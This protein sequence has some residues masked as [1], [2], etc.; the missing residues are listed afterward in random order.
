MK[1]SASA[2]NRAERPACRGHFLQRAALEP[3]TRSHLAAVFALLVWV[4]AIAGPA[5]AQ[6]A[7]PATALPAGAKPS[8]QELNPSRSLAAPP[9]AAQGAGEDLLAR[10]E[11][12]P[13]PLAGSNLRFTLT[14]V[15]FQG[16]EGLNLPGLADAS[17]PDIGQDIDLA[18]V[19]RIRDRASEILFRR[20]V[21]AR[22]EVPQQTIQNGR[23]Q[24]R[25]IAAYVVSVQVRGDAGP[26]QEQ[27]ETYVDKLRGM[28]P[29]D[30]RKAQRYVL[31]ASDLPGVRVS[32]ALRR[33]AGDPGAVDLIV[34]VSRKP[35]DALANVQNSGSNSIGPATGVARVDLNGFTRFGERN[36]LITYATLGN[37]DQKV[38]QLLS[39]GRLGG[40]GLMLRGA[41]SYAITRPGGEL[42][43]LGLLSRSLVV[44]AA[45]N[46]PVLRTR[47]LNLNLGGGLDVVDQLTDISQN[48]RLSADHLRVL[49]LHADAERQ[50]RAGGGWPGVALGADL[51]VRRG[52]TGLGASAAEG[53]AVSRIGGRA[54]GLVVRGDAHAD[55]DLLQKLA[56]RLSVSGQ[57]ADRP[58]L[59]YEQFAVGDLTIGRGY[60]PAALT[61]DQGVGGS[62]ELRAGPFSGPTRWTLPAGVNASVFTFYDVAAVSSREAGGV[63]RTVHSAGGGVSLELTPR[64][65][66]DF[67]YAHPFDKPLEFSP[68][69]PSPRVLLSLTVNLL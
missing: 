37:D 6:T 19:C 51:D 9:S 18:E 16:A 64:I 5:S 67:T 38:I 35:I 59:A 60:D 63:N 56:A 52:L 26:A 30:I 41:A 68:S 13:C 53:A 66:F 55:L 54:D 8:R 20:G 24:L 34:T 65:H 48:Q 62:F 23:L 10:P 49:F 45:F 3:T 31:L 57:Y 7:V 29:F 2:K 36:S 15:T 40:E 69:V 61:G 11:S 44:N 14:S 21:L 12:G 43:P 22:I 27:V 17:R 50:W 33:A 58:L 47:R 46:Y 28:R 32:A 4:V 42:A 1:L 25:V 39:E